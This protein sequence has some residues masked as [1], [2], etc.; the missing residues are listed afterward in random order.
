MYG[1]DLF[2][3]CIW[4]MYVFDISVYLTFLCIWLILCMY[5]TYSMYMY[6]TY[7]AANPSLDAWHGARKFS[8]SPYL[9]ASA[10]TR[11]DYEEMGEGYLREHVASNRYFPTNVAVVQ[12][13]SANWCNR[14]FRNSMLLITKMKRGIFHC[15]LLSHQLLAAKQC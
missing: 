15:W 7:S 1:F 9:D 3:V 11:R 8:L 10:I 13:E 14:G 5:L 6:L 4:L 12:K 2:F